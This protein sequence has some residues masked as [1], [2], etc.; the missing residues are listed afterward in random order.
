MARSAL[1]LISELG[2]SMYCLCRLCCSMYCLCVNVYC[3]TATGCQ[4]QLQLNISYHIIS[5]HNSLYK[6][7]NL[8]IHIH[9]VSQP[10]SP[11]HIHSTIKG[12]RSTLD[13]TIQT[14]VCHKVEGTTSRDSLKLEC[15][16]MPQCYTTASQVQIS[17]MA[18]CSM[19]VTANTL[20]D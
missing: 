6:T 8:H 13:R 9:T 7:R 20:M 4:T 10:R 16:Y 1:F 5:Y 3:T 17:D 15:T 14:L 18:H 2:C 19:L 11:V 12:T